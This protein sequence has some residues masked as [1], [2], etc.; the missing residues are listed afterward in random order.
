VEASL[1]KP[2]KAIKPDW[3][4]VSNCADFDDLRRQGC[5]KRRRR[6]KYRNGVFKIPDSER[7]RILVQKLERQLFLMSGKR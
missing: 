5:A 2:G 6:K 1:K 3:T 7:A 4:R